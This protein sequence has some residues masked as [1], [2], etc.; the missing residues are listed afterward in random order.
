MAHQLAPEAACKRLP[1]PPVGLRP[2]PVAPRTRDAP[3]HHPQLN[4]P[5]TRQSSHVTTLNSSARHGCRTFTHGRWLDVAE[6]QA[7]GRTDVPEE[8]RRLVR[9]LHLKLVRV[10]V[11]RGV[12]GL[13]GREKVSNIKGSLDSSNKPAY[14]QISRPGCR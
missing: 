12:E 14:H 2:H 10:R 3:L 5:N 6:A 1:G 9:E 11:G 7:M 13:E 4:P 8:E